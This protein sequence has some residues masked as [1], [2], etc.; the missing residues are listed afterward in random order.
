MNTAEIG[1]MPDARGWLAEQPEELR[2]AI[3]ERAHQ[4]T[5]YDGELVYSIGDDPGG[6]HGLV[7]GMAKIY[8]DSADGSTLLLKIIKPGDWFGMVAM[9]DGLPLPHHARI[10]GTTKVITLSKSGFDEIIR[11]NPQYLKNFAC[12]MCENMRLAMDKLADLGT[13]TPAQRLAKLLLNAG[14]DRLDHETYHPLDLSQT[15]M[16]SLIYA[17][18]ATVSKLIKDWGNRGLIEYRYRKIQVRDPQTLMAILK[19]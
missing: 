16:C 12:V 19:G 4:H 8:H 17:S 18:R 6:V 5:F 7:T 13:L 11:E 3:L 10:S 2:R 14:L 15:E 1:Q 9:I